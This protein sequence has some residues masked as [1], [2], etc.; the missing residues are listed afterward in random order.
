MKPKKPDRFERL[1]R[2]HTINDPFMLDS[3]VVALLRKEHKAVVRMVKKL[4]NDEAVEGPLIVGYRVALRQI[5][6]QL[7]K[8]AT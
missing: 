1:V 5:L 3:D 2:A 7:K 8:R 6:D 4:Q